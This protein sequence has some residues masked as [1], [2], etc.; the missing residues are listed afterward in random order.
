[1]EDALLLPSSHPTK[2]RRTSAWLLDAALATMEA[3]GKPVSKVPNRG[4]AKVYRLPSGE[5][6]RIRTCRRH[7]LLVNARK[8]NAE[9]GLDIE[10]TDWLLIAFPEREIAESGK[11][12]CYLVPTEHAVAEMRRAHRKW[13]AAGPATKGHNKTWELAF[14]DQPAHD[15]YS[16]KWATYRIG[17]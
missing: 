10:G 1:M 14:R 11:A 13:L 6:V 16:I 8:A 15:N 9:A 5:T 12:I 3:I 2:V 4:S 7:K 17:K